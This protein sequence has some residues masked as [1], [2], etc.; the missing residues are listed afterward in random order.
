[1]FD[2]LNRYTQ[3]VQYHSDKSDSLGSAAIE[4]ILEGA[5]LGCANLGGANLEGANL[6]GAYLEGAYLRGAYLEGANLEGA[7]LRGAYLEGAN[8][9]GANLEGANLR[10]AY[11]E[12]ANLEGAYLEGANLE[13]AYLR[14]AYL[15]EGMTILQIL[16]SVHG[17]VALKTSDGVEVRIGCRHKPLDWWLEHYRATSRTNDY[18]DAQ[19]EEY[20]RHLAYVASW[21]AAIGKT[22]V[23]A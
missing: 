23:S 11:L 4:A 18:T 9:E 20:G 17:I 10:G 3:A 22:E 7:Y 5:Y 16:G 19:I 15:P 1:M 21:A 2:I 14:G 12:G 6:R 13:G 8:L